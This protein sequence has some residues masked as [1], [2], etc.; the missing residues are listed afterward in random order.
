MQPKKPLTPGCSLMQPA[1]SSQLV[2]GAGSV[3]SDPP[4]QHY[5]CRGSPYMCCHGWWLLHMQAR[6][7][8]NL[9]GGLVKGEAGRQVQQQHPACA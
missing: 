9:P 8:N 3:G 2:Q 6:L 1:D 5:T 4:A 7:T